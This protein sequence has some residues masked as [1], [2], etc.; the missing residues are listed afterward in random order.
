METEQS[1]LDKIRSRPRFK[2]Y[3]KL[4]PEDYTKHLQAFINQNNSRFSGNINSELATISVITP[5]QQFWKPNLTLRAKTEDGKTVIRGVFGP[6][7]SI[8][9][10]FMFL[11][12]LFSVLWM[13]AI[14]LWF[15]GKQIKIEDYDWGLSASFV[16]LFLISL[17]YV[18]S[19]IGQKKAKKEMDLL[20]DFAV[21]S[22]LVHEEKSN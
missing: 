3:S 7:S 11:Y 5:E 21:E 22:T 9:T 15:V 1:T 14:T 4:P 12:F 17:T 18:A 6:G 16:M 20:R 10:F 8:W 19:L 2:M 13:V